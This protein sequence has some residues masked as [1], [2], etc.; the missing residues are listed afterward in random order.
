MG[1][2]RGAEDMGTTTRRARTIAG[3]ILLAMLA[4]VAGMGTSSATADLTDRGTRLITDDKRDAIDP[5]GDIDRW[6]IRHGTRRISFEAWVVGH[7]NPAATPAW[8]NKNTALIWYAETSSAHAGP[9]YQAVLRMV[10]IGA[11]QPYFEASVRDLRTGTVRP[12]C[13]GTTFEEQTHGTWTFPNHFTF[14]T[15][16]YCFGNPVE[17]R[18][19]LLMVWDPPPRGGRQ[20]ADRSPGGR[21]LTPGTGI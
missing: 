5:R 1:G 3:G 19:W 13:A 15:P 16:R 6:T 7:G 14:S 4:G 9:E 20:G 12:G 11:Y 2:R 17:W 10:R 21:T 18:G 8:P